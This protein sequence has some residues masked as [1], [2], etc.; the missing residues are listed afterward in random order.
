MEMQELVRRLNETAYQYYTLSAP[1]ISDAEWDKM[2][3]EL[4][5]MEKEMGIILPDSPTQRVGSA[6][7]AGFEEHTHLSRLWS[8]D[9][10]QSVEAVREWAIR[11]EKLRNSAVEGGADLPPLQFVVEHKFDGLTIN[12][13]YENGQLVQAATRG[14]G[15]TGESVLAQVKTIRS[16]PLTVPYTGA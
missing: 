15:V 2:Y 7:L 9:K 5:R 14:N 10:A 12:L 8:L 4:V 16:I 6:P 13:T 11:A 1:T 3:D